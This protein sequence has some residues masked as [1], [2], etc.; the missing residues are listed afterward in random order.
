VS[1]LML[2]IKMAYTV[3]IYLLCKNKEKGSVYPTTGREGPE[4]E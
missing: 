1:I 4:G 2:H 3:V